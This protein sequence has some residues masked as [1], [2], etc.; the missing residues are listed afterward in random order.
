LERSFNYYGAAT[1]HQPEVKGLT[2]MVNSIL[3]RLADGRR[4]AR[5]IAAQPVW[6]REG[7]MAR[8]QALVTVFGAALLAMLAAGPASAEKHTL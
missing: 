5:Q 7:Q 1:C 3:Q 6:T 2:I 8:C 4:L